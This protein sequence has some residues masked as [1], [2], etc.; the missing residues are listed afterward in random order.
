MKN[1]CFTCLLGWMILLVA[2]SKDLGNYDYSA[3]EM[4]VITNLD[5]V[6]PVLTGDRL[7]ITPEIAFHDTTLLSYEWRITGNDIDEIIYI[8]RELDMFFGLEARDYN[9]RLSIMDRSNEMKYFYYSIIRGQ[10]DFSAGIMLLTSNQGQ[11]EL[12]FIRPNGDVQADLYG[13]MYDE[14]LPGTPRQIVAMRYEDLANKPYLGYWIICSDTRL[15]GVQL[16]VNTLKRVKYLNEN[17]FSTMEEDID[18][19]YFFPVRAGVMNGIINNK[20]YLGASSTYYLSPIYGYFG[21]PTFGDYRLIPHLIVREAYYLGMDVDK[22]GLVYFDRG[23]NF[24]GDNYVVQ[25]AAFDPK[26]VNLE[27]LTMLSVSD[28]VNYIFGKDPVNNQIYEL[29]FSVK[30]DPKTITP[31]HKKNFAGQSLVNENT[32]WVLTNTE[33]IYFS[34][35]DKVYRYNPLN[36]ELRTLDKVFDGKRITLLKLKN[37][38]TLIVGTDGYLCFLNVSTGKYGEVIRDN[39]KIVGEPIDLYER[40]Y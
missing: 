8:G 24:F 14:P 35:H 30:N 3:P 16:D 38:E 29:K 5:S 31:I 32:L 20:F 33:I 10:T 12:S 39:N 36:G 19:Q 34:S 25:G 4:P 9:L 21:L 6:Y 13:Q 15:G 22:S 1:I 23:G 11:A 40:E 17:F 37:A 28:D 27:V 18:A 2:C 7:K 26:K